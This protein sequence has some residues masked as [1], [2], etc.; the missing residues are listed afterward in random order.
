MNTPTTQ[1]QYE[2]AQFETYNL[3]ERIAKQDVQNPATHFAAILATTMHAMYDFAP[4]KEAADDLISKC[5]EWGYEYHKAE[6]EV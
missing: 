6:Q 1:Q 3:L 4:S 5:I 2:H